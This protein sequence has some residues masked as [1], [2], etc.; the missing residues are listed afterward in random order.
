[1]DTGAH[2][3]GKDKADAERLLAKIRTFVAEE[4][5]D[6]E[7]ALFAALVAPAVAQAQRRDAGSG[8]GSDVDW[9]PDALPEALAAAV[10]GGG[11]RIVGLAD[12]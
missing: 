10:R 4:L 12:E 5:D 11:V 2:E 8:S 3:E 1:M 9:R 7:A 6:D